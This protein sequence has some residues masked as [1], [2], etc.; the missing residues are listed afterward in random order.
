MDSWNNTVFYEIIEVE[1][2]VTNGVVSNN[3][4]IGSYCYV[5]YVSFLGVHVSVL[6]VASFFIITDIIISVI[7]RSKE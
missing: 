3:V 4:N 5:V 7:S 2:K 6:C 1:I